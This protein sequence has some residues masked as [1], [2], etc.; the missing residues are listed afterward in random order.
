[1][2]MSTITTTIITIITAKEK[3]R[4]MASVP[5]CTTHASLLTSIDLMIS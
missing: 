5:L 3:L 4:S 1:M 2:S